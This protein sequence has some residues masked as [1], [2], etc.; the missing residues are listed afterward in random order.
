MACCALLLSSVM[1]RMRK[2]WKAA[3]PRMFAHVIIIIMITFK[4]GRYLHVA[5]IR[6]NADRARTPGSEGS[7][8]EGGEDGTTAAAHSVIATHSGSADSWTSLHGCWLSSHCASSG[9]RAAGTFLWRAP[10]TPAALCENLCNDTFWTRRNIIPHIYILFH[11]AFGGITLYGEVS[12][13]GSSLFSPSTL[14]CAEIL[15]TSL[16]VV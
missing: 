14:Y 13:A 5:Q 12:L 11:A 15:V 6:Y 2:T 10:S 4:V 16:L 8:W 3:K 9:S 1:T 7:C